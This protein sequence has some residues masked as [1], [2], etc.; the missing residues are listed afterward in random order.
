[1]LGV[2]WARN[3]R[4]GPDACAVKISE[5]GWDRIERGRTGWKISGE[6]FG[7]DETFG[8]MRSLFDHFRKL[9]QPVGGA[10]QHR[11]N[12]IFERGFARF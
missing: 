10:E 11:A 12:R 1:M 9:E 6:A 7:A 4:I 8:G 5:L 2:R 3:E